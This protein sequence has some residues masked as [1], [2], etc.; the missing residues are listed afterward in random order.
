MKKIRKRKNHIQKRNNEE[1]PTDYYAEK[2]K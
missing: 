2:Y 1:D